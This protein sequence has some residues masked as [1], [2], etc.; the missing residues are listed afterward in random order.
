MQTVSRSRTVHS[1]C[2]LN[3]ALCIGVSVAACSSTQ[4]TGADPSY[5]TVA[6]RASP[7][8]F[9]PRV[10][11]DEGSARVHQLVFSQLM[12][13]DEHLRV[14]PG[15][16]VRLDNPDPLTYIAYLWSGVKFHDG[17]E[18]TA[19]DVVYTFSSFIDPGFVSAKKD[20]YRMLASVRALDDYRVEFRLKEPFGSFPNQLVAY[21]VPEGSGDSLRT[22]P[23]GTG[24]YRFVRYA[25]D[26]D[27]V[28]SAFEGYWDGLPQNTGMVLKIIPDET[29][30]GLEQASPVKMN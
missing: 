1:V 5:V 6:I 2:I 9:D 16:A 8:N 22:F 10:G 12:T 23:I 7:T 17:H 4:A 20:A 25:V 28:L 29:R 27:V 24:P 11:S 13:L 14:A 3:L 21:V 18:L 19:K 26:E 30:R 15:L